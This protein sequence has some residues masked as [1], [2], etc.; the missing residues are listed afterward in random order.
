MLLVTTVARTI[1]APLPVVSPATVPTTKAE[2]LV[3]SFDE[4]DDIGR[5]PKGNQPIFQLDSY[6]MGQAFKGHT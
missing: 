6:V 4:S 2:S 5:L 1:S 3:D